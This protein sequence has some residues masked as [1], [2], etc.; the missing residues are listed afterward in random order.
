MPAASDDRDTLAA[1]VARFQLARDMQTFA[2]AI[3][4]ITVALTL[5][6]LP[7]IIPPL[8]HHTRR[9][10]MR[11]RLFLLLFV[12]L[13]LVADTINNIIVVAT[14]LSPGS[15]T[16]SLP[17]YP[18]Y[19][20]VRTLTFVPVAGPLMLAV[21][22]R[23][24]GLLLV[25]NP[26]LRRNL[27]RT[28]AIMSTGIGMVTFTAMMLELHAVLHL[29]RI[30]DGRA[31]PNAL[32]ET[33]GIV[34]MPHKDDDVAHLVLHEALWTMFQIPWWGVVVC[35]P[36]PLIVSAASLWSIRAAFPKDLDFAPARTPPEAVAATTTREDDDDEFS[37]GVHSGELPPPSYELASSPAHPSLDRMSA[38]GTPPTDL[39]IPAWASHG[40][41]TPRTPTPSSDRP[42]PPLTV[43]IPPLG[44][45]PRFSPTTA[46]PPSPVTEAALIAHRRPRI[47]PPSPTAYVGGDWMTPPGSPVPLLH[48]ARRDSVALG[49]SPGASLPRHS[50]GGIGGAGGLPTPCTVP[51]PSARL[52]TASAATWDF[53]VRSKPAA[54]PPPPSHTAAAKAARDARNAL[55]APLQRT[56]TVMTVLVVLMWVTF[57]AIYLVP[58]HVMHPRLRSM[59]GSLIAAVYLLLEA[60]FER[61]FR[62]TCAR[63]Q[64]AVEV[65]RGSG[66]AAMSSAARV[67]AALARFRGVFGASTTA[68]R[69]KGGAACEG[70]SGA[71]SCGHPVHFGDTMPGSAAAARVAAVDDHDPGSSP[72]RVVGMARWAAADHDASWQAPASLAPSSSWGTPLPEGASV[73]ASAGPTFADVWR[74]EAGQWKH[75]MATIQYE[76]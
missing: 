65:Q 41:P 73:P 56:F 25:T 13:L 10:T 7:L 11:V 21:L 67:R 17:D 16:A 71:C 14:M 38:K 75:K 47:V 44:R 68:A 42:G 9:G 5:A 18:L 66:M 55:R 59:L 43:T 27:L 69:T 32:S 51:N 3:L 70:S 15:T 40:L 1:V 53:H 39:V 24:V 2:P 20:F 58:A 45:A 48:H 72:P 26:R 37:R 12:A 34:P 49:T 46:A 52:S 36:Y 50:L 6:T 74:V 28:A 57:Y 63:H 35:V 62:Y 60:T 76:E 31:P 33:L 22:F 23:T 64:H 8:V 54:A 4:I 19:Y 30:L 29:E 61:M